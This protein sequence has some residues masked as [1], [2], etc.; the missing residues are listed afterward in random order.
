MVAERGRSG[1]P[2]RDNDMCLLEFHL[3]MNLEAKF[4]KAR[5][6]IVWYNTEGEN[7]KIRSAWEET[8]PATDIK[9]YKP[10]SPAHG[11]FWG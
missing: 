4:N 7:D 9:P 11:L 3:A 1:D 10:L 6:N 5:S 8:S 2:D